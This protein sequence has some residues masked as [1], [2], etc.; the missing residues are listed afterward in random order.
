MKIF[1][2]YDW[3]VVQEENLIL[4][5]LFCDNV[6]VGLLIRELVDIGSIQNKTNVL[7]RNENQIFLDRVKFFLQA[8]GGNGSISYLGGSSGSGGDGGDGDDNRKQIF[9]V[10]GC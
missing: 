5:I 9:R 4:K 10:G 3:V 8:E 1:K 6:I 7:S 2:E